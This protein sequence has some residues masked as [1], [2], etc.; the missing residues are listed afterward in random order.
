[1]RT[2]L[3]RSWGSAAAIGCGRA[4]SA[5]RRAPHWPQKTNSNGTWLP[6]LGQLRIVD[7]WVVWTSIDGLVERLT[8]T[9][10]PSSEGFVDGMRAAP[11]RVDGETS[12][13]ASTAAGCGAAVR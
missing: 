2:S 9:A 4:A 12:P 8:A 10:P 1:M 13:R 7:G 6:Q 5:P 11:E 3:P